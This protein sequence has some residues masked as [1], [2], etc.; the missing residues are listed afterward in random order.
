MPITHLRR[1][2]APLRTVPDAWFT[3]TPPLLRGRARSPWFATC[4][5]AVGS[6]RALRACVFGL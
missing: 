4:S 2:A 5:V 3:Q 6:A 1:P